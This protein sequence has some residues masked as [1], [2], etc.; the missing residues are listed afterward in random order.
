MSVLTFG[1]QWLMADSDDEDEDVHF[2]RR[3]ATAA[4]ASVQEA[5]DF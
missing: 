5:V 2:D 1:S 4:L 3:V